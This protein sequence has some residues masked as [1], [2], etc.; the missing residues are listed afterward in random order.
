MPA[1]PLRFLLP[2]F[3]ACLALC[4][5]SA[6][7][8]PPPLPVTA[9]GTTAPRDI[10]KIV[11]GCDV[12]VYE[13]RITGSPNAFASFT[14]GAGIIGFDAGLIIST[15]QGTAV[16]GPNTADG[17]TGSPGTPGYDQLDQLSGQTT[18]NA[19]ILEFDFVPLSAQVT[20]DY[21]FGSEEYNEY[22]N[23]SFN[24]TF[25][26]WLND[27]NVAL[28]PGTSTPVTINNIN[29]GNPV[30]TLPNSYPAYYLDNA[31]GSATTADP[32]GTAT[33]YWGTELDGLT[34]VFTVTATVI[35]GVIN[36]IRFAIADAADTAFDSA[37]FI[38]ANS[39][40]SG[41]PCPPT[42]TIVAVPAAAVSTP[43]SAV[44][45]PYRPATFAG[46]STAGMTIQHLTAGST[47]KIFTPSG[48]LVADLADT[49]T[50][51]S[52]VWDVRDRDG[53]PAGSGVYVVIATAP[54]GSV[55]RT[56]VAVVR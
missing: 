48:R 28:V 25:A 3:L 21:V 19:A 6:V 32:V 24:D 41:A 26:F 12:T 51:G 4:A 55:R 9:L 43:L 2:G 30:G 31:R 10:A 35:P 16:R 53:N 50:D 40:T 38:R 27:V 23:T 1:I 44:P 22:V 11:T 45:N 42:T 52:V 18:Y 20:F 5:G 37:V 47:V 56:R 17:T 36:R 46:A 34:V 39:L 7:A 49:D 8:V 13:A 14:G 54:D 33:R 29:N 15:G